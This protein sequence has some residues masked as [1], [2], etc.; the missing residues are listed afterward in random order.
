MK[1]LKNK[2]YHGDCLELMPKYIKDKSIDMI[3]CDLPY[4]TTQNKWDS[5][6]DLERLWIQYKRVIKDNG[7]IILTGQR[8][9][10]AKLM[11]FV[12]KLYRYSIIWEKTKAGGFLNA[13]RM[14]LQAHED[15]L[16]FYKKLPPYNPQ[17]SGGTPYVKKAVT[18]GDGKNYGKFN[19]LGKVKVNT[20]E[21]Y[22][23]SVIKFSND[24]H[25]SLHPTQKPLKLFEWLIATYSNSGDLVLDNTCGSGTTGL[26]AKNL[27]RNYIMMEKDEKYYNIAL[28]RLGDA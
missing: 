24:N 10:S 7:A 18:N 19:R 28:K 20:G 6:I 26:A 14:P 12:P 3:L 15:I 25:R 21:R 9:F 27:N 17:M 4:G 11:T 8:L 1:M 22:P 5:I 13:N 23:R 16:V 2:I